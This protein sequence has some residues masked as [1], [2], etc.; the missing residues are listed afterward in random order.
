MRIV[1]LT[2]DEPFF[3]P[4]FFDRLFAMVGREVCGVAIVPLAESPA[5]WRRLL[6]ETL[7]LYGFW[8]SSRQMVA[9]AIKT[10]ASWTPWGGSCSVFAVARRHRLPVTRFPS[11]NGP[12]CAAWLHMLR[13]DLVIAQVPERVIPEVLAIPTIGVL[14]KHASLLPKY[15]GRHPIF[16]AL[17]HGEREVGVTW[18]LMDERFDRGRV[19][20]QAP[21]PVH[22]SDTVHRLYD[23]VFAV[24]AELLPRAMAALGDRARAASAEPGPDGSYHSSPTRNDVKRFRALGWRMR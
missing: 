10:V 19:L 23:R 15:R 14:N 12:P 21:I 22:P 5:A 13:P 9:W 20:A 4:A 24:G 16:W 3:L 8:G 1:I 18:H 2:L 6:K 7:L 11:V 17:L